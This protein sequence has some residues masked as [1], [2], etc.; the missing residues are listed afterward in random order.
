MQTRWIPV[1]AGIAVF[2]AGGTATGAMAQVPPAA[3]TPMPATVIAAAPRAPVSVAVVAPRAPVA[4]TTYRDH[5]PLPELSRQGDPADSLYR[6]AR[7]A[8]Q[9]G[10]YREAADIMRDLRN[11]YPKSSYVADSYYWEAYALSRTSGSSEWRR[12]ASVLDEQASKYPDAAAKGDA[13]SLRAEVS[14]RLAR[15]GDAAAAEDVTRIA[16]SAAT[17]VPPRAPKS[18]RA[19]RPPRGGVYGRS[20]AAAE[21]AVLRLAGQGL[22]AVVLRPARVFGP[23][24]RIFVIRP[25]Q[26]I[27]AGHFRWLGSPDVPCDMVYVDNVVEAILC[28]LRAPAESIAGQ[29][30]NVSDGHEMTWRQF[31]ESLADPAVRT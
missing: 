8:L 14:A 30:F 27:A 31:Y 28:S 7:N 6:A 23:F 2:I 15:G 5:Q 12:A 22:P 1:T 17:P 29:A 24:S 4:I 19:P 16:V 13:R 21:R 25:I 10:R 20:K 26:A 11:R 3:P 18:P 9:R